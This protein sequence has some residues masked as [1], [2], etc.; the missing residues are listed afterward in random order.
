MLVRVEIVDL[1]WEF[2]RGKA[3]LTTS[4]VRVIE[5]DRKF[6]LDG[7][8]FFHELGH[9]VIGHVT[10]PVEPEAVIL[11]KRMSELNLSDHERK[12]ILRFIDQREI[13]AETWAW[14]HWKEFEAQF[15]PF[16]RAVNG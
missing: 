7:E 6:A 12:E 16:A 2:L 3:Y 9:H 14:K 1:S 4:G 10:L 5:L 8:T 11:T 13:E 15:G